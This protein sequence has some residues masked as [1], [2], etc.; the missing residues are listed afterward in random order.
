MSPLVRVRFA[1]SPT[2]RLHLGNART[3]LVNWLFARRHGGRFVLRIDD[4][5][6]E[7]SEERWVEAIRE[8]LRWLGLDWDEEVRQSAREALY[9]AAFER[10]RAE[11]RVYPCQETAEQL[12]AWR[13]ERRARG[14]PPVFKAPLVPHDPAL[15]AHWRFRLEP[16]PIRFEDLI[17]GER[18][19]DGRALGDPV[20]R[21]E[22]GTATFLFASVVDDLELA[23]SHVIRGEDHVTNTAVQIAMMRALGAVPPAFAHLPLIAD[24][25]GGQLSKRLGSLGLDE[26]RDQ[27]VEPMAVCLALAALGTSTAPDPS[28]S[29]AELAAGSDLATYGRAAP[30]L[31]PEDLRRLT[32]EVLHRAPLEAVRPRLAALGFCTIEPELWDALKGS[33]D[34]LDDFPHWWRIIHEPIRPVIEDETHCRLAADLLPDPPDFDAWVPALREATGR[35]GRALFHP[36]R[37]ALTGR[38]RGP[39]LRHLLALLPRETVVRRLR[40]ETA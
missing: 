30:R 1:P 35:K 24:A 11:G 13:Q 28:Q 25:A 18:G 32:A 37:L 15:P 5:D 39:E 2:G 10:L 26:L 22:D 7:R 33:L 14:E 29:L 23:I 20:V 40:G 21:R 16:G 9:E 3:A 36:L 38:E 4:T 31:D 17:Q 8:D 12:A 27:G 19:F 6:R 34:R